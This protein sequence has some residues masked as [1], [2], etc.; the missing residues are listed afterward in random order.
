MLSSHHHNNLLLN[1]KENVGTTQL[2][3]SKGGLAS[4]KENADTPMRALKQTKGLG[5]GGAGSSTATTAKTPFSQRRAL[6][7]ITNKTPKAQLSSNLNALQKTPGT[8]LAS[9]KS[10]KKQGG[11]PSGLRNA[12][13]NPVAL[14]DV[15]ATGVS[16]GSLLAREI[17]RRADA[18]AEGGIETWMGDTFDVQEKKRIVAE[19][20]EVRQKVED[21]QN[22]MRSQEGMMDGDTIFTFEREDCGDVAPLCFEEM[23]EEEIDDIES[24]FAAM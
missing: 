11:K 6:G 4:D 16:G 9:S 24:L 22:F 17:E 1:D 5:L 19:A 2:K 18:F 12:V 15:A 14:D 10:S 13:S 8:G 7:N 3:S 21:F 23:S 20:L